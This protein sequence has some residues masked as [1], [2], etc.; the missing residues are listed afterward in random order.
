MI[1]YDYHIHTD[2]SC[3]CDVPMA[4]MCRAAIARGLPEIGF[5]EHFDLVPEDPCYASFR[6]EAWWKELERCRETF[7][8]ALVIR[9]GIEAGEPHRFTTAVAQLLARFPW[10][11]CLGALHWVGP[12]MIW[13]REYYDQPEDQAYRDYFAELGRVAM[14]GGFD[15]LAHMDAL[16]RYGVERYGPYDPRRYEA[17]IRAVL[18]A[19]AESD[20][21]LEINTSSL[22]RSIRETS[23]AQLVLTWFRQEGGRWVTVGSD[24]HLPE[25]VGFGLE[26]C[27]DTIH[28]AGFESVAC[29]ERRRPSPIPITRSSAR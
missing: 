26:Q 2:F 27:L 15:I 20:L 13:N 22:R 9:A 19:C 10:D 18:R 25:H 29:F 11:Y 14:A 5:T 3:D 8:E 4:E 28:A 6:V 17:D 7:G 12:T 21:A 16:K 24:A 23:P 1:P